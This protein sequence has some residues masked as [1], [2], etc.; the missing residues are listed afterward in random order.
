M[1]GL[2]V[3]DLYIH[4]YGASRATDGTLAVFQAWVCVSSNPVVWTSI[5]PGYKR[6]LEKETV[7]RHFVMTLR[8]KKPSWALAHTVS[9]F[10]PHL[11][12]V[13]VSSPDEER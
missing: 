1:S 4:W 7:A 12:A 5:Q 8:S 6:I 9:R 10:Y 13:T 3:D 11:R 2:R